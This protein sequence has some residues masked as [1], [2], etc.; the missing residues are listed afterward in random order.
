MT[1]QWSVPGDVPDMTGPPGHEQCTPAGPCAARVAVE[2]PSLSRFA[3]RMGTWCGAELAVLWLMALAGWLGFG[4]YSLTVSVLCSL[5]VV[6]GNGA[7]IAGTA[8][9]MVNR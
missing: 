2:P 6:A 5:L 7:A 8:S 4:H 9:G 3:A 1:T